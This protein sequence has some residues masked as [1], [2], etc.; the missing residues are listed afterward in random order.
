MCIRDRSAHGPSAENARV[1]PSPF[2]AGSLAS[3]M[4]SGPRAGRPAASPRWFRP[5]SRQSAWIG[6]PRA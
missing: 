2:E 6:R 1:G 4:Y 5:A 3:W